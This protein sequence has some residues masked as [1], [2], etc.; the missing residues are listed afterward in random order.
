[1]ILHGLKHVGLSQMR[2]SEPVDIKK[3]GALPHIQ[4]LHAS[5][6]IVR[7]L[8]TLISILACY[9]LFGM[10]F[11]REDLSRIII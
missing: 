4:E 11:S 3:V 6:D 1:M 10:V 9:E 8:T 7:D 5:L 2:Y